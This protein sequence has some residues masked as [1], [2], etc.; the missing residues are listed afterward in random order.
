MKNPFVTQNHNTALVATLAISTAALGGLTY[1][2]IRRRQEIAAAAAELKEHA[3]DYLKP[4]PKKKLR[5][6][7][8]DL[9]SLVNHS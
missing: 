9:E 2:F 3:S 1:W 7:K 5:A 8:H 4:H 6:D